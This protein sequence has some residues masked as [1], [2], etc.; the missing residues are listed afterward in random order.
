MK[1][2]RYRQGNI[3]KPGILDQEGNILNADSLVSDWDNESLLVENLNA[4][5]NKDLSDIV[6]EYDEHNDV[7]IKEQSLALSFINDSD[8]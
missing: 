3:V 6:S 2:L 4:I 5:M 1:T 8:E 7:D